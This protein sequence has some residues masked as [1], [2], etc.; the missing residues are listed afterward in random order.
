VWLNDENFL[1]SNETVGGRLVL[2]IVE[3]KKHP[4]YKAYFNDI[5]LLKVNETIKLG[6][7]EEFVL[8]NPV[9]LPVDS[10]QQND[11]AGYQ[12][13]VAGWGR[14]TPGGKSSPA[15]LKINVPIWSNEECRRDS[16]YKESI[17]VRLS[18]WRHSHD[19]R[20]THI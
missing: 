20:G 16:K 6:S 13:T 5:A 12:G 2:D 7:R 10:E 18:F 14:T 11:Y 4:Q 8:V 3:I 9:C 15:L 17:R 1:L 19:R